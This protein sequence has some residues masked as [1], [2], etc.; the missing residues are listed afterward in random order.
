MARIASD[1]GWPLVVERRGLRMY[2]SGGHLLWALDPD[3]DEATASIFLSSRE[4]ED[5]A[6]LTEALGFDEL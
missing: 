3:P 5:F 4:V 2:G 6:R 1:L